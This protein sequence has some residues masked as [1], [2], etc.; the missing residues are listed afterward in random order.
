MGIARMGGGVSKLARMLWDTY[1]EKNYP[2]SN[3]HLLGSGGGQDACQG[4]LGHLCSEN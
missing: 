1:L 2:S 3:R 4:G